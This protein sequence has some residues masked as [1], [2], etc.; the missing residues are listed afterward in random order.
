MS[1]NRDLWVARDPDGE[2]FLYVG[3]PKITTMNGFKTWG[4]HLNCNCIGELPAA[5]YPQVKPGKRWKL[6]L[7]VK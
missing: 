6:V 7:E 5:L 4:T 3:A 1:G 2:L